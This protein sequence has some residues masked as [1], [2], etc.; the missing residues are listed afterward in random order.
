MINN[1]YIEGFYDLSWGNKM[2]VGLAGAFLLG[3][4]TSLSSHVESRDEHNT[5][6]RAVSI[7]SDLDGD[8]LTSNEEWDNVYKELNL[9]NRGK[10]G[11]DITPEQLEKY[12]ANHPYPHH[13]H[14]I[15]NA[16]INH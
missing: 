1:M 10:R 13:N 15:E 14:L 12:S 4:A 2:K 5:L 6:V 9:E 11:Y 3:L 8:F 16:S 7:K